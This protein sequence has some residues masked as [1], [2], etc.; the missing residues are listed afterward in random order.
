MLEP[1]STALFILLMVVFCALVCWMALARQMVFRVFAACL[2]F[3]PAMLFGVAAVNKY[4]DYYQTWG[5]VAA[6]LGGQGASQV[7]SATS[8]N[9]ASARQVSA[10]L[11][12]R[13]NLRAAAVHGQTIRLTVPGKASHLRRTVF[14]YLPPQYFRAVVQRLPVPGHR[15]AARVP[16]QPGGLDQRGGHHRRRTARCWPTVPR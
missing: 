6:D 15:A 2:A 4:Y 9:D 16:G 5:A 11:G 1:Q 13:V 12:S 14:V 8:V 3:I 7:T 10:I